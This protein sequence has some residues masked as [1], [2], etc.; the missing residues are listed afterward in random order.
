[1][2]KKKCWQKFFAYLNDYEPQAQLIK[3]HNSLDSSRPYRRLLENQKTRGSREF[4]LPEND[5]QTIFA[6]NFL[7][8]IQIP[9]AWKPTGDM[10]F[11][12]NFFAHALL[13]MNLLQCKNCC[14]HLIGTSSKYHKFWGQ[15][16]KKISQKG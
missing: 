7:K 12:L 1:M 6:V 2:K 5:F 8:N 16:F 3:I 13:H 10:K 14:G 15:N 4:F 9:E 11:R